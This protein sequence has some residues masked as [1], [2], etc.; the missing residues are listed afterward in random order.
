[1]SRRCFGYGGLTLYAGPFVLSR[2]ERD[3]LADELLAATADAEEAA[4]SRSALE[5]I[6]QA[7]A[8]ART[9]ITSLR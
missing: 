8:E 1:M 2:S 3:R 7:L 9:R 5:E 4:Q 6:H